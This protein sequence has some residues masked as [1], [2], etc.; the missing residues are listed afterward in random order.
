AE[1]YMEQRRQVFVAHGYGIRKLNQ[2]YFAFYGGYQSGQPGE[3]GSDPIGPA[4][5]AI[6]D[7]SSSILEWIETMR[8]IVTRDELL[9]AVK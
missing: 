2:A 7:Q 3:G 8:G 9:A 5:Q 1:A 4:V 6:R